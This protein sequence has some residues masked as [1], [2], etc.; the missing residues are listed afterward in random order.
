MKKLFFALM[1][2]STMTFAH[3]VFGATTPDPN[4]GILSSNTSCYTPLAPIQDPKGGD[5]DTTNFPAYLQS[6]YRIGIGACFVLGVIMFTWAGIEYVVSESMNTKTDAKKRIMASLTGL[7]IAL[8]SFILLQT[9]N[10][11]LVNLKDI[12]QQL[13]PTPGLGA[14]AAT[15]A[16]TPATTPSPTKEEIQ[17]AQQ[18]SAI[19]ASDVNSPNGPLGGTE[20]Q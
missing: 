14:P 20:Y 15:P 1:L 12:K 17:A 7:A 8:V 13:V 16:A 2:F 18:N 4:C 19:P 10:P 6:L 9:I 3:S 5:V 11:A